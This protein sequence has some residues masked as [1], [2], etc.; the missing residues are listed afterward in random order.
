MD[1]K[2][3]KFYKALQ[4]NADYYL[5]KRDFK[6][7]LNC[8]EE[9][10]LNRDKDYNYYLSKSNYCFYSADY[11]NTINNILLYLKLKPKTEITSQ[12][13]LNNLVSEFKYTG[14]PKLAKI[15]ANKLYKLHNDSIKH[16]D[17]VASI[18]LYTE[19]YN[20]SKEINMKL[21]LRDST[22][23]EYIYRLMIN[24]VYMGIYTEAFKYAQ[25]YDKIQIKLTGKNMPSGFKGYL[26]QINGMEKQAIWN[27]NGAMEEC[28]KLFKIN[29]G[30]SEYSW[31]YKYQAGIYAMQGDTENA[32]KKLKL[33][34][35]WKTAPLLIVTQLK[36]NPDLDNL[37]EKPEFKEIKKDMEAKY[38]KTHNKIEKLLIRE[39]IIIQ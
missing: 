16:L 30:F 14:F 37:R 34:T 12:D 23:V 25:M 8:F 39:G 9:M 26:Y 7:A 38:E 19:D 17:L 22:N 33:L 36:E 5:K 24:Y 18:N 10:W 4:I 11:Y 15:Y 20:A 32:I 3:Y 28:N 31:V 35:K 2:G 6:K 13:A 29:L 21:H 1:L 27:F